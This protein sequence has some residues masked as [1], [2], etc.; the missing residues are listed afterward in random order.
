M[1]AAGFVLLAA[2][3]GS[4]TDGFGSSVT[5]VPVAAGGSASA[6]QTVHLD[7]LPQ[8]GDVLLAFDDT[9]SMGSALATAKTD[10]TSIVSTLQTD[11]AGFGGSVQ[12]AVAHFQDYGGTAFDATMTDVPWQLDQPLTTVAADVQ[13]A[14]PSTTGDGGDLPESYFRAFYEASVFPWDTGAERFLIVLGDQTGHDPAQQ[15]TYPS[16]PNTVGGVDPGVTAS[17][18]LSATTAINDLKTAHVTLSFVHYD[19]SSISSPV[20]KACHDEL[21]AATGGSAVDGG[22]T[23]VGS[24]ATQIETL[25]QNAA[26]HIGSLTAT[27]TTS[28]GGS[29][30]DPTANPGSWVSFTGLPSTIDLAANGSDIPFS[31]VVAPPAG[32][33]PGT[34]SVDIK[35]V[36]DNVVRATETLTITVKTPISSLNVSAT[37]ASVGAGIDQIKLSDIPNAWLGY[38]AG[39]ILSGPVGSTPVG[40]TPVGSTPVG[41]TPGRF[42]AGRL[43]A[44][45]LDAGRF[46]AGGLDAGRLHRALR[47]AGRFDAGRL[48]R[49]LVRPS[50]ADRSHG[51]D[52]GSDSVCAARRAAAARRSRSVISR[53]ASA[54]RRRLLSTGSRRCR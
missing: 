44:G 16:C 35:V 43:D 47:H 36:A 30:P 13:N 49:A 27:A 11:F 54:A 6:A 5:T 1:A 18:P 42:D 15:S 17:G 2:S 24:V 19:T 52:L 4:A 10:T 21:A 50:L 39:S 40:S 37:P 34:Y 12:F 3:A 8:K 25:V 33:V 7:P 23:G 53:T 48:H 20:P 28:T 9:G 29:T 32:A 22:A 38:Y 26:R 51:D 31:A 45:G 41:S 14:I 46:D